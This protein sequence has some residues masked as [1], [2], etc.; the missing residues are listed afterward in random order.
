[1]PLTAGNVVWLLWQIE[2]AESLNRQLK[3][4]GGLHCELVQEQLADYLNQLYKALEAE[5]KHLAQYIR[6]KII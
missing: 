2:T 4:L 6:I 5:K 1:M 3:R